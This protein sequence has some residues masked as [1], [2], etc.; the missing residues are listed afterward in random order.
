MM[1]SMSTGRSDEKV[2]WAAWVRP[3]LFLAL[4]ESP[5]TCTP[6][7]AVALA[8]GREGDRCCAGH[9]RTAPHL[10]RGSSRR[11]AVTRVCLSRRRLE[12]GNVAPECHLALNN[13]ANLQEIV[14]IRE[15]TDW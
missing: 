2:I 14:A 11:G 7:A 10:A 9:D 5:S 1:P 6:A 13:D 4:A 3:R 12:S 8:R 15:R